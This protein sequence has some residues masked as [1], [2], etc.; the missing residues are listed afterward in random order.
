MA[1][2]VAVPVWYCSLNAKGMLKAPWAAWLLITRHYIPIQG[3]AAAAQHAR[4]GQGTGL[5]L[6][7]DREAAGVG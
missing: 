6:F 2:S 4:A 1:I 5:S 3:A 7:A